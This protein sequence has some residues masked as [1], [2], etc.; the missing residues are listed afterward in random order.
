MG[1]CLRPPHLLC[2]CSCYSF[3][4]LRMNKCASSILCSFSSLLFSC[5]F[6]FLLL[7]LLFIFLISSLFFFFFSSLFYIFSFLFFISYFFHSS[8][9]FPFSFRFPLSNRK[10]NKYAS[11]LL[12]PLSSFSSLLQILSSPFFSTLFFSLILLTGCLRYTFFVSASALSPNLFIFTIL[13]MLM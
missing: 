12:F 11:I 8:S 1:T 3:C 5:H 2:T 4:R 10:L 7:S 13:M 6:L 9:L